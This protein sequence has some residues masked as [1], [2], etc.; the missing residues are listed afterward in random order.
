MDSLRQERGFGS[1]EK[2]NLGHPTSNVTGEHGVAGTQEGAPGTLH[3]VPGA[4]QAV[5]GGFVPLRLTPA[6]AYM[7]SC[8]PESC[9]ERLSAPRQRKVT[10]LSCVP[11][12]IMFL[13]V[14]KRTFQSVPKCT[15]QNVPI[16][17]NQVQLLKTPETSVKYFESEEL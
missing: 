16:P 2:D 1:G 3:R 17:S 8:Q 5:P 13:S 14:P 15:F 7:G 9:Q 6:E 12:S 11:K 10:N 4:C